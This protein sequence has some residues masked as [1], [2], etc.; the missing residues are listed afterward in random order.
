MKYFSVSNRLIG[1]KNG[2]PALGNSVLIAVARWDNGCVILD[3]IYAVPR[4]IKS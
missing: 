1:T 4:Q 3:K 2:S